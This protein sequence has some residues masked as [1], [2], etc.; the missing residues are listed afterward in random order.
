MKAAMTMQG[1]R[2]RDQPGAQRPSLAIAC[3]LRLEFW[4]ATGAGTACFDHFFTCSCNIDFLPAVFV[5][6]YHGRTSVRS[7]TPG[8]PYGRASWPGRARAESDSHLA[9]RSSV[10]NPIALICHVTAASKSPD[11]A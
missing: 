3:R 1:E 11:S 5:S 2:N 4:A 10:R 8:M 7:A 6:P 9:C